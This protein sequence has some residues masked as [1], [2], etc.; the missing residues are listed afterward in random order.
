M[1]LS[2]LLNTHVYCLK[3]ILMYVSRSL[4]VIM[5]A[6]VNPAMTPQLSIKLKYGKKY[7]PNNLISLVISLL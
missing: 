4:P 7:P 6:V 2:S 3:N 1:F 5:S